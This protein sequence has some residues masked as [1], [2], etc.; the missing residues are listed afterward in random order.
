MGKRKAGKSVAEPMPQGQRFTPGA[1]AKLSSVQQ[2][3]ARLHGANSVEAVIRDAVASGNGVPPVALV[4]GKK[5]RKTDVLW[6]PPTTWEAELKEWVQNSLGELDVKQLGQYPELWAAVRS[7]CLPGQGKEGMANVRRAGVID[8]EWE[9]RGLRWSDANRGLLIFDGEELVLAF[10]KGCVPLWVREG[11]KAHIGRLRKLRAVVDANRLAKG[12]A[13]HAAVDVDCRGK[14][15][16]GQ[17][18]MV[19]F[20][21]AQEQPHL[22]VTNNRGQEE[23]T[24]ANLKAVRAPLFWV[25]QLLKELAPRLRDRLRGGANGKSDLEG[26]ARF[27][28]GG[29]WCTGL[30]GN[31]GRSCEPHWDSN[32]SFCSV[33]PLGRWPAN[34]GQLLLWELGLRVD[35]R[36]GDLVF[37]RS[38]LLLH[39]VNGEHEGRNTLVFFHKWALDRADLAPFPGRY[40]ERFALPVT[41]WLL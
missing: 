16:E 41:E 14:V 18:S 3:A 12:L 20:A 24:G 30:A 19:G 40:D 23:Q 39:S 27:L 8:A 25:D 38:D 4:G 13:E 10:L 11:V 32:D 29:T 7:R 5:K 36:E 9:R 33:M 31:Y 2:R 26:V 15:R 22:V 6:A 1:Y 17:T 34:S 28:L 35:A 21:P 37:F